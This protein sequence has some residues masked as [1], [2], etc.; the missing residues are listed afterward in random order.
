VTAGWQAKAHR[1]ATDGSWCWIKHWRAQKK[2]QWFS[3]LKRNRKADLTDYFTRRRKKSSVAVAT[4]LPD[5]HF[6]LVSPLSAKMSDA[7][8]HSGLMPETHW[9]VIHRLKA[10]DTVGRDRAL[11]EVCRTYWQP[12]YSLARAWGRS[13]HDAEDLTQAFFSGFCERGG[14]GEVSPERGRFRSLLVTAFRNHS[15]DTARRSQAQC[16]GGRVEQVT[17]DFAAAEARFQAALAVEPDQ[18]RLCDRQWALAVLEHA[19]ATCRQEWA[20]KGRAQEFDALEPVL[21]PGPDAPSYADLGQRLALTE[22]NVA[23]KVKRLR[24]SVG[25]HL[26]RTVADTVMNPVEVRDELTY[27]VSLL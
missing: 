1:L 24:A 12:L 22:A 25:E 17:L 5:W 7:K 19:M 21:A 3:L 11:A 20:E 15:T 2:R 27:L 8:S 13:P 6:P 18:T 23:T 26:R 10:E 16:R 4:E 14:L 9:S